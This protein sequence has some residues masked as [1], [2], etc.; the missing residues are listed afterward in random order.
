MFGAGGGGAGAVGEGAI[1]GEGGGGGDLVG[2]RFNAG[3]LPEQVVVTVGRGGR[4][5]LSGIPPVITLGKER[6]CR[7]SQE[8]GKPL[9]PSR[10]T[11]VEQDLG[12]GNLA[13]DQWQLFVRRVWRY[14]KNAAGVLRIAV[15]SG[16][17]LSSLAIFVLVLLGPLTELVVGTGAEGLT[18][19]ERA[20]AFNS[21][22]QTIMA[23]A[24]GFAAAVGLAFTAR[25]YA[26]SRRGQEFERFIRAVSLL[27]SGRQSER[28]GGLLA[29][30]HILREVPRESRAAVDTVAAFIRERSPAPVNDTD[31]Q[32]FDR[33]ADAGEIADDVL[34]AL[35]VLGHNSDRPGRYMLDLS[36][37]DM[38]GAGLAGSRFVGTRMCNCLMQGV[39]LVD[40]DVRYSR[41]DGSILRHAWLEGTDFRRSTLRSVD[42]RGA[43]LTNARIHPDQLLPAIVDESTVLDAPIRAAL[44][45]LGMATN[46]DA[47]IDSI[48]E[49]R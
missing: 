1:G 26:L 42:L 31:T 35:H 30:E 46:P 20:D 48:N 49:S 44:R 45:D 15:W 22:R 10:S 17:F 7:M 12:P 6:R 24:A 41:L 43:N 34:I 23:A 9:G 32:D 18:G 2:K 36:G 39:S 11:T 19:K 37:V 14:G 47:V 3:E 5:V 21:A 13:R 25:A 28:I 40:A 4:G 33:E 27:S 38:R 29:I 16:L 8:V